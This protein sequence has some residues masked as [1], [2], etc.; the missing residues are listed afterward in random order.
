MSV[1]HDSVVARLCHTRFR[2]DDVP[3]SGLI[4]RR[5]DLREAKGK[6]NYDYRAWERPPLTSHSTSLLNLSVFGFK[7]IRT[8]VHLVAL[9][10]DNR[11][12]ARTG[13]A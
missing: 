7:S 3:F 12:L 5:A 10:G 1:G 6:Y 13:I 11:E 2:D 8:C 4:L 9:A